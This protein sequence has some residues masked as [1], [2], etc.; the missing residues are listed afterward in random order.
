MTTCKGCGR[1]IEWIRTEAG[2]RMPVDPEPLTVILP[3]GRLV[4]GYRPH[5]VTCPQ[6]AQFRRKG[7]TKP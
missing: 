7:E 5:W 1:Q 6:A 3:D 2:K 4:S